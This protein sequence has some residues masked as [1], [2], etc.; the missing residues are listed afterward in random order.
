SATLL[1]PQVTASV[2][3]GL[4]WITQTQSKL[5]HWT[6]G[7]YPTAMTALA[8]TALLCS[9]S[10]TTQGPYAQAIRRAVDYL[11]SRSRP[12]GLIGDPLRD[13]RYTYGHG[14]SML[15]LSQVLG[16]EEDAQRREELI[17]VLMRAVDFSG[18]AQTRS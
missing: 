15:M 14:F 12:N 18:S 16:E 4:R 9:G 10:T 2:E 8:G 1:A 7:T 11:V 13:N 17:E 5:G 3:R 6:A